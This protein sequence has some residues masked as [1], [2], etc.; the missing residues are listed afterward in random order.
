MVTFYSQMVDITID[1]GVQP[2][3]YSLF[4][5]ASYR[6]RQLTRNGSGLADQ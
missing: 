3:P 2:W 4:L 1:G 5:F 6:L